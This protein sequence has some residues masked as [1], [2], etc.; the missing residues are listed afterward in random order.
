MVKNSNKL[1]VIPTYNES[2]NVERLTSDLL[3]AGGDFDI[4]FVDDSSPDGTSAI[5]RRLQD[6][7]SQIHLLVRPA[8]SG[9]GSAHRDGILWGY[10][11]RYEFVA[12]MDA[13]LT[14]AATDL[15]RMFEAAD[16]ADVIVASRFNKPGS[17]PGWSIWRKILTHSGHWLTKIWLGLPYDATGALRAYNTRKVPSRIFSLAHSNGYSF[18][19]ESLFLIHINGYSVREIP[20]VLPARIT[21]SSKM[22]WNELIRSLK[23]ILM[24]GLVKYFL[25]ERLLLITIP[26]NAVL[27]SP[28]ASEWDNYWS[29]RF[30]LKNLFYDIVAGWY[31][32]LIIRPAFERS[33]RHSFSTNSKLLHAGCGGGQVD[34]RIIGDFNITAIDY[35]RRALELYRANNGAISNVLQASIEQLPFADG[36]FDGV[37]NLGVMEHFP[38]PS[39]KK[40]LKEFAR[41][42]KPGG[43]IVI[44]WPPEF[45]FSVMVLKILRK[46]F[47]LGRKEKEKNSLFPDEISRI[48]SRNQIDNLLR[49]CGFK[50]EKFQFG[51]Q[52][53]FT[54]V[55]VI[56]RKA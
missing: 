23:L 14:H 13:D 54:Q 38:E 47:S 22:S 56:G 49:D 26:E 18:I 3:N 15:T 34:S 20:V 30:D 42:L 53:L 55:A 4:L 9:I 51:P 2:K 43:R 39:L 27:Q 12:T 48:Q 37:Y 36:S 11:H 41:V 19:F 33:I 21:G 35:S 52:D 44:W 8:K 16:T 6:K 7:H 40:S 31:R 1:V 32:R 25:P 50:L 46:L 28:D 10:S 5:I 24:F 17:L 45:G 29:T